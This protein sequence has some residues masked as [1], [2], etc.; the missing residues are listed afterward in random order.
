MDRVAHGVVEDRAASAGRRRRVAQPRVR[1]RSSRARAACQE[2][3][4][5]VDE[6]GVGFRVDGEGRLEGR[7]EVPLERAFAA[8]RADFGRHDA[9][10]VFASA[11]TRRFLELAEELAAG[12]SQRGE[13]GVPQRPFSVCPVLGY[14]AL[15]EGNARLARPGLR[16]RCFHGVRERPDSRE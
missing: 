1:R 6:D 11:G 16:L 12:R 13:H 3:Q 14:L 2:G 15:L 10:G 5:E 8:K 9:G 7:L 4:F